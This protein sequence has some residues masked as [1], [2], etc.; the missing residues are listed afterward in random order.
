[1]TKNIQRIA[2]P[3][4]MI[5]NTLHNQRAAVTRYQPTN[6]IHAKPSSSQYTGIQRTSGIVARN[7]AG[8]SKAQ[9]DDIVRA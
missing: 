2:L 4:Q 5:L 3:R 9:L 7:Q 6:F 8:K 1:M